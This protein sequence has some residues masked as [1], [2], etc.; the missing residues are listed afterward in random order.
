MTSPSAGRKQPLPGARQVHRTAG[1]SDAGLLFPGAS[2]DDQAA[3]LFT[4]A[5]WCRSSARAELSDQ[6]WDGLEA[7]F[8][9]SFEDLTDTW[10]TYKR[11]LA[12]LAGA[13]GENGRP[14]R[15]QVLADLE[16]PRRAFASA[17][18]AYYV[19]LLEAA[20][21]WEEPTR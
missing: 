4:I 8:T 11:V 3:H 6:G 9:R 14:T 1:S 16:R 12:Y 15:E 19:R 5:R 7:A 21:H 20:A 17:L 10:T 18:R 2:L 13:D